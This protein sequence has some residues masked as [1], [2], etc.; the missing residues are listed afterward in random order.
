MASL[1]EYMKSMMTKVHRKVVSLDSLRF[2][3]KVLKEIRERESGID[4]E[5]G[6]VLDMYTML[7]Y[8]ARR[9]HGQGRNG[10]TKRFTCSMD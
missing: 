10:S 2:V 9:I 5:I 8:F 1:V 3:M 7:E 4:M 6:P